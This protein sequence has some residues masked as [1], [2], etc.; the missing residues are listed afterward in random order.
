MINNFSKRKAIKNI[1]GGAA[2]T[3]LTPESWLKPI[4]GSVILPAHAQTSAMCPDNMSFRI[5]GPSTVG[6]GTPQVYFCTGP[7]DNLSQGVA[8]TLDGNGLPFTEFKRVSGSIVTYQTTLPDT[9]ALGDHTLEFVFSRLSQDALSIDD[10]VASLT[11]TI[12]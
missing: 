3:F 9:L 12:V 5:C 7:E 11:I 8:L 4:I 2:I 10:I 1:V 6:F